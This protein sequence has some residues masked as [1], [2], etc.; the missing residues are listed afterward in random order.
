MSTVRVHPPP[1]PPTDPVPPLEN[2]DR[3]TRAE[4]ERRYEA[5]PRVKRAELIEGVVYMAAAARLQRH[6]EPHGC[7]VTWMGV[8]SAGT[9]GIDFADNA[10]DRLDLDNE[11]QPDGL[12]Y[13]E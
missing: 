6:G 9:E 7:L 1:P 12:L 8:Y 11:P 5:M 13:I 3:L 10:S 4:F 2:G